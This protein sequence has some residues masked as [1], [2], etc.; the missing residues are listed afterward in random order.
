M[1]AATLQ[2]L[3]RVN[4]CAAQ[5]DAAGLVALLIAHPLAV[6]PQVC[7]ALISLDTLSLALC[8]KL[9]CALPSIL[10]SCSAASPEQFAQAAG[11]I[12]LLI[13]TEC[14]GADKS[15]IRELAVEKGVPRATAAGMRAAATTEQS[16]FATA[17]GSQLLSLL[18]DGREE[19]AASVAA[20]G[21]L[22]AV[23]AALEAHGTVHFQTGKDDHLRALRDIMGASTTRAAAAVQLRAVTSVLASLEEQV[24][25]AWM[26]TRAQGARCLERLLSCGVSREALPAGVTPRH[27]SRAVACLARGLAAAASPRASS[28]RKENVNDMFNACV[29]SCVALGATWPATFRHVDRAGYVAVVAALTDA[30]IK[31][32][33]AL[34][35]KVRRGAS[36]PL[37]HPATAEEDDLT[38]CGARARAAEALIHVLSAP[39]P[40]LAEPLLPPASVS[41]L[42]AA[43]AAAPGAPPTHPRLSGLVCCVISAWLSPRSNVTPSAAAPAAAA[44]QRAACVATGCVTTACGCL[45]AHGRHPHVAQ[46]AATAIVALLAGEETRGEVQAAAA[47]SRAHELLALA[48]RR[49]AGA[50]EEALPVAR[51]LAAL[52]LGARASDDV[53]IASFA[54]MRAAALRA[55]LRAAL[56]KADAACPGAEELFMLREAARLGEHSNGDAEEEI[57]VNGEAA[58]EAPLWMPP[59]P[60]SACS[61]AGCGEKGTQRCSGCKIARYCS[62]ACQARAW[63]QHKVVCKAY[64]SQTR[65]QANLLGGH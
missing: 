30:L 51:A 38:P 14:F 46:A 39:P 31:D 15:A 35:A 45:A 11:V 49:H 27:A 56:A 22:E 21:G 8:E 47:A 10:V 24:K 44:P 19:L 40:D 36:R 50:R 41:R 25:A 57:E 3:A 28:A 53:S 12:S 33:A 5:R 16:A 13:F 37:G 34:L 61:A 59:L 58:D 4:A 32:H 26:D 42:A 63:A 62:S 17:A 7:E 43:L 64:Q 20:V 6:L 54:S 1:S 52:L 55:G 65:F 2:L 48:L 29:S 18:I 23:C 9:C 60:E